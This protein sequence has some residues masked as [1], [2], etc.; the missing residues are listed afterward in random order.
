M[1]ISPECVRE[2]FKGLESGDGAAFFKHVA[3]QL[4]FNEGFVDDDLG[5][6]IRQFELSPRPLPAFAWARKFH[7]IRSTSTAF[8]IDERE[9]LRVGKN[10]SKH[11]CD[12]CADSRKLQHD[13]ASQALAAGRVQVASRWILAW[14]GVFRF[15]SASAVDPASGRIR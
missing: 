6:H 10:P 8:R 15:R 14:N 11:A 4:V 9:R 5:G 2:I 7:C 1:P 12:D 13:A 3:D